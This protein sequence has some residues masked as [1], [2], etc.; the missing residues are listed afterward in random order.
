VACSPP[1][2]FD[3]RDTRDARMTPARAH[4]QE[5]V[6]SAGSLTL[7]DVTRLAGT[8]SRTG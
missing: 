6:T 7:G 8:G 5:G 2:E 4:A 1:G 3:R